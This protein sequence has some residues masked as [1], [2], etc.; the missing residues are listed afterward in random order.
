[1]YVCM[2]VYMQDIILYYTLLH[3]SYPCLPLP[4]LIQLLKKVRTH[5]IYYFVLWVL[6]IVTFV[7]KTQECQQI[8]IHQRMHTEAPHLLQ[9]RILLLETLSISDG[10]FQVLEVSYSAYIFD[11]CLETQEV[12]YLVVGGYGWVMADFC[13]DMQCDL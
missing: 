6:S 5:V 1:M 8:I 10:W 2:S 9:I 12:S 3:T 7:R 4:L 13:F 11:V